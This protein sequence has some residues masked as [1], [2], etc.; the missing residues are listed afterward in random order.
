MA[1]L[2]VPG[3]LRPTQR[4]APR[5]SSRRGALAGLATRVLAQVDGRPTAGALP[6]TLRLQRGERALAT[7]ATTSGDPLCVTEWG[8]HLDNA[9]VPFLAWDEVLHASANPRTGV[10]TLSILPPRSPARLVL[11]LVAG[12]DQFLDLVRDRV[13]A[14]ALVT[15]SVWLAGAAQEATVAA[16]RSP[17]SGETSWRVVLGALSGPPTAALDAEIDLA[18]AELRASAGL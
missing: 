7:S 6:A 2:S 17:S 10:L 14:S 15:A 13:A 4:S 9:G 12:Q 5:E 16:R 1:E 11:H 8:L 3:V 18:V